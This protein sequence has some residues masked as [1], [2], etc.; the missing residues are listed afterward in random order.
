[1]ANQ[2]TQ[3]ETEDSLG[4]TYTKVST[5]GT[6]PE[7]LPIAASGDISELFIKCDVDNTLTARMYYSLDAGD[8]WLKLAP[9]E[10]IGWSLKNTI[11]Q[12]QIKA[13]E[14][15]VSYEAILNLEDI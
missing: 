1:M 3:F 11:T 5:V 10:F 7:N 12:V 8:T 14:S 4:H 9:G 15:N 6:T 13:N 2:P